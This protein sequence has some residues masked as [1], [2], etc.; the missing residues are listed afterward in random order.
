MRGPKGEDRKVAGLFSRLRYVSIMSNISTKSAPSA[1]I[2]FYL[3]QAAECSKAAASA[4]LQNVRDRSLRSATAWRKMASDIDVSTE[5][6]TATVSTVVVPEI[7]D[8]AI[9]VATILIPASTPSFAS[10]G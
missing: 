3:D 8:I 5:T 10:F 4:T 7:E 2:A 6:P 1:K 9:D